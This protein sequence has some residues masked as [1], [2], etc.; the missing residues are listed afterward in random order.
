MKF[1]RLIIF[2]G[3]ILF[4]VSNFVIA[5]SSKNMSEVTNLLKA[6]ETLIAEKHLVKLVLNKNIKA[7]RFY[8]VCLIKGKYFKRNIPRALVVLNEGAKNNDGLSAFTLGNFFSDGKFFK[9]KYKKA[10]YYYQIALSNGVSKAKKR[11]T[12]INSKLDDDNSNYDV[13]EEDNSIEIK[14]NDNNK[15]NNKKDK[16]KIVELENE[17]DELK[18][19]L[20]DKNVKPS[21]NF[22]KFR[23]FSNKKANWLQDKI[24]YYKIIGFGSS[25]AISRDGYFVT[26]EHVVIGC[27]RVYI[28]YQNMVKQGK[29]VFK[30][31]LRDIALVKVNAKTPSY[32]GFKKRKVNLGE[33]IISGGFPTPDQLNDDIKITDGIV[34]SVS[35]LIKYKGGDS[36]VFFQHT[37]PT[38]PGNSGGPLINQK[39]Q[40]VG[41]TTARENEKE[42]KKYNRG[43]TPQNINYAVPSLEIMKHLKTKNVSYTINDIN[44][45]YS[46]EVLAKLLKNTAGQVICSK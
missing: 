23:G 22:K 8:A 29:V 27:N 28:K 14:D 17:L 33:K 37:T 4:N 21:Q 25:F 34:S 41:M 5:S 13:N 19:I 24:N 45:E 9:P 32:F 10:K 1:I 39:G 7:I 6:G 44:N 15:I 12:F 38:Q 30:S 2:S 31:K 11:I 26:N 35:K 20:K 36:K 42:F 16:Q 40:V 18:R 43:L 46:T 3:L